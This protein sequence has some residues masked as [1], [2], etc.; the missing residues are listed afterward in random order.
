VWLL[1]QRHAIWAFDLFKVKPDLVYVRGHA[2]GAEGSEAE[3][4]GYDAT[5][6]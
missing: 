4:G 6:Y 5:A 2:Y 1:C 3:S